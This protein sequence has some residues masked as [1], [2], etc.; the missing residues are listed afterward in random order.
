MIH[1]PESCIYNRLGNK[2]YRLDFC[3]EEENDSFKMLHDFTIKISILFRFT[4]LDKNVLGV[5]G[6]QMREMTTTNLLL[7]GV[8]MLFIISM[9]ELAIA[10]L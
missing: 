8:H 4:M 1:S 3:D 7:C 5:K 6:T 10:C 9:A 2:T